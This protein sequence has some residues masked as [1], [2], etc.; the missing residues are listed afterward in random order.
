MLL[1]VRKWDMRK[2]SEYIDRNSSH[3]FNAYVAPYSNGTKFTVEVAF[4]QGRP[5]FKY[6]ENILKHI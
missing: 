6:E 2:L 1:G 3:N 5:H 4:T